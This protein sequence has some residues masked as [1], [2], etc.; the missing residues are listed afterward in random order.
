M[1]ASAHQAWAVNRRLAP[2]FNT[3]TE[4]MMTN[5]WRIWRLGGMRPAS[6]PLSHAP[7]MI[8]EMVSTKNQKNCVGASDRCSPRNAG[9][10][11]TYR[12]MPLKG[13]PLASASSTKRAL[14]PSC[15]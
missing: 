12:N 13:T 11:S 10:D 1:G 5:P 3:A 8:P 6:L 4:N 15:T 14:V 2:R 7:P 9:A